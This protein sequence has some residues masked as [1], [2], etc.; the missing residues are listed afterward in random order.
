MTWGLV[1]ARFMSGEGLETLVTSMFLHGGW[2]HLAGNML[3]LWIFGDNL[4]EEMGHVGFLLFY[5]AAGA[6]AGL[7]QV[8]PDPGSPVPDGGRVGGDCRGDGGLPS[9]FPRA[10]VDVLFIFVIFFRIFAIPAWIVLGIWLGIQIFSGVATPSDAGGVAYWAHVGRL[11][12]GAGPDPA[13]LAA[14]G[15]ARLL[16]S[17][18]RPPA[19]PRDAVRGLAVE[20]PAGP[21]PPLSASFAL[22]P[23]RR[24]IAAGRVPSM[25][26]L[27]L[28]LVPFAT[29]AAAD[30]RLALALAVDVSRSIDSQDYVIQTDGLADALED[31]DVRAAIFGP[32]GEVALAIYYWS[33]HAAIRIWCSPG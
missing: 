28:L 19:A 26:R 16:A 13:G 7:A 3:F 5:L 14:P 29:P 24:R 27:A 18:R 31:K 6:A 11:C 10:K 21:P 23:S 1:P 15:R 9:A 2:M 17:D 30:C 12:R 4:E 25:L 32:E 33:R 22:P 8:L 20:H